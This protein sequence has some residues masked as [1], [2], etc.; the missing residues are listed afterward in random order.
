MDYKTKIKYAEEVAVQLEEQKSTETIETE[1]KEKGLYNP[2][3]V[4]VMVSARKILGEKYQ[5]K[6]G[7]YLL[8]DKQIHGAQDFKLL[9]KETLDILITRETQKLALQEKGKITKL[10]K[11]GQSAEQVFQ[12]VDTRF[13]T[14]E[15]A[16]EHI[17][18]LSEVKSQ[19]SAGGRMINI[20]GGIGLIVLTG[21]L[22]VAIDRLFYVL[23]VIGLVMIGKGL[24]TEKM[25]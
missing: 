12:Q 20:F 10:M 15:K 13:L 24:M 23:P 16:A 22:M 1:L 6:I 2:D 17:A 5:P 19:N 11:E 8:N 3:V 25:E 4:K 9:D 14:R 18:R 7:E 21:I